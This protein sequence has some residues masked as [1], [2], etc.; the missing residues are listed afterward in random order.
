M[1][2]G[3]KTGLTTTLMKGT[4]SAS[5]VIASGAVATVGAWVAF[6]LLRQVRREGGWWRH[7]WPLAPGAAMGLAI[8]CMHFSAMLAFGLPGYAIVYDPFLTAMSLL[9]A[10]TSTSLSFSI[11]AGPRAP[12]SGLGRFEMR[13]APPRPVLGG[14]V[15]GLGSAAL[16]MTGMAAVEVP[17]LQVYDRFLLFASI[18]GAVVVSIA[19]LWFAF[20]DQSA[21]A[22]VVGAIAL[23]QAVISMH[24]LAMASVSFC[25][26]GT[27]DAVGGMSTDMLAAGVG[28]G[29]ALLVGASLVGPRIL[30]NSWSERRLRSILDRMPIGVILV[31]RD[32]GGVF[33]NMEARRLLTQAGA[34]EFGRG[35][36]GAPGFDG[37]ERAVV[38]RG[39]EVR[40]KLCSTT[41]HDR[42]GRPRTLVAAIRSLAGENRL[43][44]QLALSRR[45]AGIG[46]RAGE[47]AHDL[48]NLLQVIVS[49]LSALADTEDREVRAR[50]E[51]MMGEA[52]GRGMAMIRQMLK[53]ED[54]E[55]S[56]TL[57]LAAWLSGGMAREL[58]TR[59][60]D[61]ATVLELIVPVSLWRVSVD[62][63]QMERAILNLAANARDAMPGGGTFRIA[64]SNVVLRRE[65]DP[66]GLEGD[67]V[68]LDASDTGVGMTEEVMARACE[69][70]FTTK[71]PQR[72]TGLGLAQVNRFA[73]QSRGGLRL[74]SRVGVGTT[75]TL[76]LPRAQSLQSIGASGGRASQKEVG[77]TA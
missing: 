12:V 28:G 52:A 6:D 35:R 61:P 53:P 27:I 2:L 14:I 9:I 30:R 34:E 68:Q 7:W 55:E 51:A 58:L 8:W 77:R 13:Q 70:L 57:D 18:V 37:V 40:I 60:L 43:L 74:R 25:S 39:R 76:L 19:A 73:R 65:T 72:G 31:E 41:M 26:P 38:I 48:N 62:A 46:A 32:N 33:V 75:V 71:A 1:L 20:Q 50:V 64:A 3:D 66:D 42:D 36:W 24:Y 47:T 21:R 10:V 5:G 11:A 59:T 16:H 67:F 56:S 49:G 4:H 22:Q 44:Q 17:L 63:G 15:M 69:P 54:A 29:A 45:L 23:G